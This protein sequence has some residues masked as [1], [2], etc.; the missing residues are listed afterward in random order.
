MA[1]MSNYELTAPNLKERLIA[2]GYVHAGVL[3]RAKDGAA[4]PFPNVVDY[5]KCDSEMAGRMREGYE[6]SG[7]RVLNPETRKRE[8]VPYTEQEL[9]EK[10]LYPV[11]F[12]EDGNTM[13]W[14]VAWTDNSAPGD[15]VTKAYPTEVM[16]YRHSYDGKLVS[17]SYIRDGELCTAD[18]KSVR[19]MITV[20]EKQ[21][22]DMENGFSRVTLPVDVTD[23]SFACVYVPTKDIQPRDLRR[24]SGRMNVCIHDLNQD[25]TVYRTLENGE[26]TKDSLA[27]ED[28]CKM[29]QEAK[30]DYRESKKQ[31]SVERALP[32]VADG[33]ESQP[34]AD[35][36][37]MGE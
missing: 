18:G 8:T 19:E 20:P 15:F 23:K 35:G 34:E 36:P 29:H 30:E 26:R 17:S 24:D 16:E 7:K 9:N 25:V 21:V 14:N 3:H 27:W 22:K 11:R 12:S 4:I 33:M 32:S 28:V 2:D 13:M 6:E 5:Q 31:T 37:S 10:L 1:T